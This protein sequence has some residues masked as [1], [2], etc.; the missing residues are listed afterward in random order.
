MNDT[1]DEDLTALLDGQLAEAERE[2]VARRLAAEPRLQH[3]LHV[4]A[5]TRAPLDAAFAQMLANA[6]VARLRAAL[7]KPRRVPRFTLGRARW[8]ASFAAAMLLSAALGS[9]ITSA[10]HQ[11]SDNW[12]AA[13]V[14]YMQLYTPETFAG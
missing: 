1:A 2:E 6:P 7:P 11:E 4:L 14:D 10:V 9:W 5:Q 8:A 12:V 3:R 13:V